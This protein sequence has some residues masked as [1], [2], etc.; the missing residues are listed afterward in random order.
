MS[1]DSKDRDSGG[2]PSYQQDANEVVPFVPR[3]FGFA[4]GRYKFAVW[5]IHCKGARCVVLTLTVGLPF[6]D[7]GHTR[8]IRSCA[9][10]HSNVS[11]QRRIRLSW[12]EQFERLVYRY[13]VENI[14]YIDSFI[15][16]LATF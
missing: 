5:S 7:G 3:I 10:C 15:V 9:Q 11:T 12:L 6:V 16:F 14:L 8:N 2:Q 4:F 1:F 13:C